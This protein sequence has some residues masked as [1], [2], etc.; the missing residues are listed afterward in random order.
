M[1]V[2]SKSGELFP[3]RFFIIKTVFINKIINT[4]LTDILKFVDHSN[5]NKL[6]SRAGFKAKLDIGFKVCEYN[7]NCRTAIAF[8]IGEDIQNRMDL[9]EHIQKY[10]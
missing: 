7:Q 4:Y 2:F 8:D 3:R 10:L 6:F 5:I 9:I 1:K